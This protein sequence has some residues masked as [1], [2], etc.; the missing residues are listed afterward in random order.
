MQRCTA[1]DSHIRL[2]ANFGVETGDMPHFG[3]L[4]LHANPFQCKQTFADSSQRLCLRCMHEV[5]ACTVARQVICTIIC[6]TILGLRQAT[7]HI[8][9]DL[10]CTLS[11]EKDILGCVLACLQS[12][13]YCQSAHFCADL[14]PV[15]WDTAGDNLG[16][17]PAVLHPQMQ[18]CRTHDGRGVCPEGKG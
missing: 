11:P 6:M 8:L 16:R 14:I 9:V 2:Y 4:I 10:H 1:G 7:C 13:M 18:G 5:A 3:P 15:S 12:P 17:L